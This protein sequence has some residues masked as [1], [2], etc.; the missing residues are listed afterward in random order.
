[1]IS[2]LYGSPEHAFWAISP[3]LFLL[4]TELPR[5]YFDLQDTGTEWDWFPKEFFERALLLNI[6][7][8]YINMCIYIYIYWTII[9]KK[10][11]QYI[12]DAG[13][14]WAA[15]WYNLDNGHIW[16]D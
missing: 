3:P 5:Y 12:P 4:T 2:L 1:M 13:R 6:I 9:K 8:L 16:Y 11:G 7:K 15:T 10:I 14:C